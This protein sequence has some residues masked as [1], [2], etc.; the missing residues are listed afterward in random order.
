M[1]RIDSLS[2]SYGK[3]KKVIE[4]LTLH[5][6]E[7]KIHAIA[8]LNG[9]GKTTL[10]NTI[11]GFLEPDEG[12]IT[13][14]NVPLTK[15]QIGYLETSNFFYSRIT[16]CEYLEIFRLAN[17]AFSIEKWNELFELPLNDLIETYSTGMKKKLAFMGVLCLD[18]PVM[19]LDEPFNGVDLK[20]NQKLKNII[21][22]LSGRGKTIIIT[23]HILESLIS[24]CDTIHYLNNKK[25]EFSFN[26]EEFGKVEEKIFSL[27]NEK[28]NSLINELLK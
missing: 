10:L 25:I 3:N 11:F 9:S 27:H 18:K 6:E 1:L 21:K 19:M 22:I 14:N 12:T 7:G 20:S 24:L 26:K 13:F 23:S 4:G 2:V 17:P 5:L 28:S 15:R 8:G 16:G